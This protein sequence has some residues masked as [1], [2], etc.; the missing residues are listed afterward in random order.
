MQ[1]PDESRR[2]VIQ[3]AGNRPATTPMQIGTY[4]AAFF[5]NILRLECPAEWE[6]WLALFNLTLAINLSY[7]VGAQGV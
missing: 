2:S 4:L 1:I 6:L 3:Q 7:P 5:T